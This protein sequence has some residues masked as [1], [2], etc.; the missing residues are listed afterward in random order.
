MKSK[1]VDPAILNDIYGLKVLCH[2]VFDILHV[3][4]IRYFNEAKKAWGCFNC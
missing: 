3:G 1:L 4:H 2:G